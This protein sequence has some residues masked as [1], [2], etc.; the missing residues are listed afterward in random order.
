[1]KLTYED[2]GVNR[3]KGYEEVSMIKELVKK[4]H[5]D[6]VLNGLGGFA[7]LM[8]IKTEEM[9]DPV[10]V[11]GTDGVGTKLMIAQEMDIHDTIGIDLVAM[12]VNDVLCQGARPLFFLDYIATGELKPHKMKEIV[13]GVTEGCLQGKSALIGGETAEMPGLYGED[14]YDLA[15][16]SV[17]IVDKKDIITGEEIKPG[18]VALAL[19]SSGIHSNGYSLVRLVLEKNNINYPDTLEG[20]DRPIGEVLLEPT[21]IYAKEVLALLDKIDIHGI[22]HITG[23]GIYENIPRVLPEGMG[24]EIE[25]SK[26]HVPQVFKTLQDL[27]G[28]ET[29]E[30]F[31]TFNMGLGMVLFIPQEDL[32]LAKEVLDDLG[33]G[34]RQVGEV[35]EAF[36]GVQLKWLD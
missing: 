22:A 20:Y 27:G 19:N 35:T 29:T 3:E 9:E 24:L 26:D 32:E 18:D 7:G 4:T 11:S 10:L 15:G 34:Y 30:M 12:C 28:I 6:D 33:T 2:S 8:R 25:I 5:T 21:R 23:G 16:F 13:A 31:N 36:E 1:M 14:D 17:G